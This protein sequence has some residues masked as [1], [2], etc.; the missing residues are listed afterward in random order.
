MCLISSENSIRSS[1]VEGQNKDKLSP[2]N[3]GS[4]KLK[5][6]K[7]AKDRKTKDKN[8]TS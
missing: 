5:N 1:L 8:M 6:R 2:L 4:A 3:K 7:K